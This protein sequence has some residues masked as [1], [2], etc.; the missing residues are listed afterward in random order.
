MGALRRH[1]VHLVDGRFRRRAADRA[2]HR[3][4]GPA[5]VSTR[6]RVQA[7]RRGVRRRGRRRAR[8]L[9]SARR[10]DREPQRARLPRHRAAAVGGAAA[11]SAR[12]RD[13]R[14]P[15][16]G[17]RRVGN[18]G[19]R[20]AV[21]AGEP[22]RVLPAAAHVHDQRR[23]TEPRARRR[24][25]AAPAHRAR[26]RARPRRAG[27]DGASAH[28]R[29]RADHPG[30]G[31]RGA[32]A[33]AG[34]GGRDAEDGGARPVDRRAG[35]RFQQRPD[36]RERSRADA[37]APAPGCATCAAARVDPHRRRAGREPHAAAPRLL[38]PANAQPD[39]GEPGR[40]DRGGARDARRFSHR[41]DRPRLR[42]RARACG[43]SR[44]TSPSS[45][46]R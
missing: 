12:H 7:I 13:R 44:S 26:P 22:Q 45:T 37:A 23:R 15:A 4:V 1:L 43:R 9:Q 3:A 32:A 16:V 17:L 6:R 39:R 24:R 38:A 42:R 21:R 19:E 11:Q 40:T 25:G 18:G 46:W 20:R 41:E 29:A 8:R 36:D 2:G 27:A 14:A 10:A 35:P 28:P 33:Q 30:A 34:A 5:R 31:E